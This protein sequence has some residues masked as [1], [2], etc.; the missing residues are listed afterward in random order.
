MGGYGLLF[1]QIIMD[2]ENHLHC[3]VLSH[4]KGAVDE[5]LELCLK[6]ELLSV[7]DYKLELLVLDLFL[8][9]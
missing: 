2:G 6:A 7:P 3:V 8:E 1:G 9:W 5:N 4:T